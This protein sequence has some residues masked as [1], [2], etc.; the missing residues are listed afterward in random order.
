MKP[1][2]AGFTNGR[3]K[4]SSVRLAQRAT[5]NLR[6]V[7]DSP[8]NVDLEALVPFITG[9]DE[10][11]FEGFYTATSGLLFGLLLLILSDTVRAEEVLGEVY[12]KLERA[13]HI[14]TGTTKAY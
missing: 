13:R 3:T 4:E 2:A 9:G 5:V 8:R 10:E 1:T 7:D 12:A 14:S 11:A 6:V